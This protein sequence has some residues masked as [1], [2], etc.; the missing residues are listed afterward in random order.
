[1]SFIFCVHKKAAILS[2][3][4]K[5]EKLLRDKSIYIYIYMCVCVYVCALICLFYLL[6]YI[7]IARGD[8]VH[9][10]KAFRRMLQSVLVFIHQ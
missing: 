9:V 4:V 10:F 6:D 1:M 7:Y 3:Y 5:I 2:V 8:Y